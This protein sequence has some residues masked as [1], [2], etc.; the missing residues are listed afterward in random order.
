MFGTLVVCLPSAHQGGEVVLKH[1][2]QKKVFKTSE[3]PQ[4]FASWYSD[5]SHK[6]LPVTSGFRWVL[7]YNLALHLTGPGPSAGLQQFET[8]AL[9]RTLKRWISEPKESRETNCVYHVLDHD[10]TEAN[11]S[12]KA[13]KTRDLA[14]VHA[15]KEIS[16]EL[17]VDVFLALLEREEMGSCEHDPYEDRYDGFRRYNRSY[18]DDDGYDDDGYDDYNDDESGY[19]HLE[20]VFETKYAVK[21]LVDL[22]GRVVATRLRLDEQDIL[23]EDCFEDLEAEEEYEGY[24]G[25]SVC[26]YWLFNPP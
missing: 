22:Q 15:L 14:Q 9:R 16:G 5:V 24:M 1:C 8:G 19:H 20:E 13:L 23:Q 10:Y 18:Y 2:G 7:T 26:L 21:T 11:I 17:A 3:A 4:S 6:V 25:N 12:L